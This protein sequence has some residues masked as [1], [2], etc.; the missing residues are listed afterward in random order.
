MSRRK[1]IFIIN[2]KSGKGKGQKVADR[3]SQ[4]PFE[5]SDI[6]CI[7]TSSVENFHDSIKLAKSENPDAII[8]VGG[9]GTVNAV[10]SQLVHTEI[11]LG[12]IPI[13][14]GNGLAR[15][16]YIP[17]DLQKAIYKIDH[18]EFKYIDACKAD[19]HHF[20]CASGI[21]FDARIT[22]LF[23]Q[24]K[25]RG[26]NSYLSLSIKEFFYNKPQE[27]VLHI[28]GK[29]Y[30]RVAFLIAINNAS[31]YGNNAYIAP[32]ADMQDGLLDIT[33]LKPFKV[34]DTPILAYRLFNK[35]IYNS[36]KVEN[37]RGKE[38]SI[39]RKHPGAMHYDGEA[40]HASDEIKYEVKQKALKVLV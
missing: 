17:L 4:Y 15:D 8:A 7:L 40:V 19:E 13:G 5:N 36:P 3:V 32:L 39:Q 22:E 10:A 27:Y 30:T 31:Q 18:P 28:D 12:I 14:S 21:G 16:L 38:I 29:E 24:S 26:F 20:F 37:F 6:K 25:S 33:V 23:A 11:A 1:I 35:K 9:D 34:Y 2:P